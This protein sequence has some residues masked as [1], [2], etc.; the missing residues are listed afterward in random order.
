MRAAIV[1]AAGRGERAGG[2]RPKQY[3]NLLG[4]PVL[5][6][7]LRTFALHPA[8]DAVQAV[9]D[10]SEADSYRNAI[11]D[12]PKCLAPVAGGATRQRS[13]R[14]GL[15]AIAKL[16]PSIVLVHD[17]AR[18]LASVALVDRA[19]AAA[20]ASGAAIPVVALSDTIK[21]VDR[22]GDVVATLDRN[23][24]RAV[25]TPQAFSFDLLIA[26]H[27]RA[28]AAGLD[29]FTDDAALAEWAGIPVTTFAGEAGNLKL[30]T[31]DDFARAEAMVGAL[32]D[33]RTGT[34]FDVHAFG[35]GKHVMLGG[36][37]IP[38]DKGVIGHS[39]AD[40]LLHALT[41]AVL[42][43][44]GEADIGHHFPPS[45]EKWRGAASDQFLAFAAAKVRARG[46]LIAHLDATVLSESPKLA[47]HRDAVR[48]RIAAITGIE[49][50]RVSVKA[51]TTEGLG[52]I[53]RKEGIAAMA[54]A[55]IRLPSSAS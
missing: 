32:T 25:Q 16:K 8:I 5:A 41:D 46:G 26:A 30:T 13:V 51:T 55:T 17:A 11:G 12:L 1:V 34:G 27:R 35:P 3:Q 44:L 47:P 48:A 7:A 36:V 2:A 39:D 37:A 38:H 14:A 24:L 22:A 42:G 49:I 21:R 10:L 43:A 9:I 20:A 31:A 4:E 40:V 45:Q 53:G 33:V 23:E 50:S 15:E 29:N 52:F 19:L 54:T 28:S 6:R 18:P